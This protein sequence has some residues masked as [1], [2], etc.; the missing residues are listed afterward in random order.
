[1]DRSRPDPLDGLSPADVRAVEET[2]AWWS[3]RSAY[4]TLQATRPRTLAYALSDSPAGLLAW[5]ADLEWAVGDDVVP[6]EVTVDRDDLLTAATVYWL[7][8]TAGSSARIYKEHGE[9]FRDTPYTPTPTAIASFPR[10]GTVR[11]LAER[12]HHVVQFTDYDRGGHF[13]ALQA[14]DLLVQDLRI[15]AQHLNSIDRTRTSGSALI[16]DAPAPLPSHEA[17]PWVA[18]S[19]PCHATSDEAAAT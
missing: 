15:F 18:V 14:P 19:R 7:T 10:D 6:G 11:A 9:L 16:A 3:Q 17:V 5:I 1:M 8:N 2:E 12:H 13:A 4:A